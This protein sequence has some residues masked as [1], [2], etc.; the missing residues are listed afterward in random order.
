M[1]E[2]T[3]SFSWI[4][5]SETTSSPYNLGKPLL[6]MNNNTTT[7]E[8]SIPFISTDKIEVIPKVISERNNLNQVIL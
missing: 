2:K 8:N 6:I 4:F 7:S 3:F 1:Q 5:Y